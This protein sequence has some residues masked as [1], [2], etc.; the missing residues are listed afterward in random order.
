MTNLVCVMIY[1]SL[2]V[3]LVPSSIVYSSFEMKGD[4]KFNDFIDAHKD[5]QY[6]NYE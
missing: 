3:S 2:L 6:G 5:S 4:D 1:D